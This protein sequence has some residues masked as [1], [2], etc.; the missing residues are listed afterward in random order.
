V[1]LEGDRRNHR[2]GSTSPSDLDLLRQLRPDRLLPDD[3]ADP[4]VLTLE[5]V[6]LMSRIVG[7]DSGEPAR[8]TSSIYPHLA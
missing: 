7:S 8:R 6:R 5:K 3:P 4:E 1:T 2:E